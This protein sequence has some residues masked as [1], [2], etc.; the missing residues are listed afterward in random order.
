[1]DWAVIQWPLITCL[2]VV[3]VLIAICDFNSYRIPNYLN[4]MVFLGGI[5]YL[6]PAGLLKVI[7]A[8]SVSC[9]IVA[10][11]LYARHLHNKWTGKI[12]IGM[13]DVKFI[14]AALI[15]IE[16]I[17]IPVFTLLASLSA[18]IYAA[19]KIL[20][21][22]KNINNIRIPFG[23]FLGTALLFTIILERTN[24]YL[25]DLRQI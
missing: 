22:R 23:P 19:P 18:L 25:L 8:I 4:L 5:I 15:W 16:P 3:V 1:M 17:N 2:T 6:I 21:D 13:G 10:I 20:K 24:F 14:F 11:L 12:G 9:L 7:L